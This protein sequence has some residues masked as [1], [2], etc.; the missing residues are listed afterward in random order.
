MVL[1]W[2]MIALGG[3]IGATLRKLIQL[4]LDQLASYFPLGTLAVNSIGCFIAGLLL[5][6][7]PAWP[8][9]FKGFLMAGLL[10]ALTTYSSFAVDIVNLLNNQK[11]TVA[12]YY[13]CLT[14]FS[15]LGLCFLGYLLG[16][17]LAS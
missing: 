3:A 2:M 15:C 1:Q 9:E 5:P 4:G 10:G 14:S 12:L 13:F 7:W 8:S 16:Q 6:F 11:T 17:K